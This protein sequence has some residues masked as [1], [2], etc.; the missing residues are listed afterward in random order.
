VHRHVNL[1]A[2]PAA[3]AAESLIFRPPF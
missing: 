3:R 2:L 1:G